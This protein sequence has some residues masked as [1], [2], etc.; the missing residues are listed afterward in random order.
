MGMRARTEDNG[1]HEHGERGAL[2]SNRGIGESE[3]GWEKAREEVRKRGQAGLGE[4]D[5]VIFPRPW[6]RNARPQSRPEAPVARGRE[7]NDMI[8]C[9]LCPALWHARALWMGITKIGMQR[10]QKSKRITKVLCVI[11]VTNISCY[12]ILLFILLYFLPQ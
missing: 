2:G 10:K 12:F 8:F 1:R 5:E 3:K 4:P 6:R 9:C 11:I 7:H